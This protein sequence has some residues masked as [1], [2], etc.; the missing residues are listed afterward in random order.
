M[1]LSQ[2]LRGCIL[3]GRAQ[4]SWQDEES[5]KPALLPRHT[6]CRTRLDTVNTWEHPGWDLSP[7]EREDLG[8]QAQLRAISRGPAYT[9]THV[10]VVPGELCSV[11]YQLRSS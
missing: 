6:H 9:P 10:T 8:D 5:A 11:F 7:G 1:R 2:G 4:G 3:E